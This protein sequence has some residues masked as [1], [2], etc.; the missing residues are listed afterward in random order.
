V[1]HLLLR[2]RYFEQS[3]ESVSSSP[4]FCVILTSIFLPVILALGTQDH[5]LFDTLDDLS[6]SR[7]AAGD[8]RLNKLPGWEKNSWGYHG[9]D[10]FSFSAEKAGNTYGPTFGGIYVMLSLLA[11]WSDIFQ[12]GDTVG[13][14]IDFSQSRAFFTKNGALIGMATKL[15]TLPH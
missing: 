2:T 11:R 15:V 12:G 4:L 7:F 10:G 13:A 1:W 5:Q 14:G 3:A 6:F 8:A 9:D